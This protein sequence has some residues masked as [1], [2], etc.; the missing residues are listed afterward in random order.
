MDDKQ[1][2]NPVRQEVQFSLESVVAVRGSEN[3]LSAEGWALRDPGWAAQQDEKEV[4]LNTEELGVNML[5]SLFNL[6]LT[7]H[8]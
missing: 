8:K 5:Q 2:Y 7:S 1:L 4:L 6:Q 3:Q